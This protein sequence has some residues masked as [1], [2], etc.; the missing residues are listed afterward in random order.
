MCRG[1]APR[2]RV[3]RPGRGVER[4]R[5]QAKRSRREAGRLG[6]ESLGP[7]AL[8]EI[9]GNVNGASKEVRGA[10]RTVKE[11]GAILAAGFF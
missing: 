1:G 3:G 5:S 2:E 4:C 7:H 9:D 6:I 8:Q 11:E 10:D